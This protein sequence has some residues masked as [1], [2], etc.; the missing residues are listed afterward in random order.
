MLWCPFNTPASAVGVGCGGFHGIRSVGGGAQPLKQQS[1]AFRV[2]RRSLVFFHSN[3]VFISKIIAGSVAAPTL[4][5]VEFAPRW[6]LSALVVHARLV[7]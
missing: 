1:G 6:Q 7:L 4:A 2:S 3:Y 5:R